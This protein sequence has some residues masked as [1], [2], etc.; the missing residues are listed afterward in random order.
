MERYEIHNLM[1]LLKALDKT[2]TTKKS[3]WER[4]I[5]IMTE[6]IQIGMKKIQYKNQWKENLVPL[7]T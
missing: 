6:I 4:V 2:G 5:E 1:M 3:R 7:K